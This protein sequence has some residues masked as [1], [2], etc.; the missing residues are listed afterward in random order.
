MATEPE[1]A[2][3]KQKQINNYFYSNRSIEEITMSKES[4]KNVK[5]HKHKLERKQKQTL[6]RK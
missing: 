1:S 4:D 3:E 5:K 6:L 2:F